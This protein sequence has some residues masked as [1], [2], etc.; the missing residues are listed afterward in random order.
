MKSH[1]V[2]F[3]LVFVL[4]KKSQMAS[5]SMRRFKVVSLGFRFNTPCCYQKFRSP[6]PFAVLLL[7]IQQLRVFGRLFPNPVS[8]W[9]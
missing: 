3:N 7:M 6:P 1:R 2:K 9:N 8:Q 4:K 5:S